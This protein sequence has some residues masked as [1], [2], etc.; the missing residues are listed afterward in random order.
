MKYD[1]TEVGFMWKHILYIFY[2]LGNESKIIVKLLYVLFACSNITINYFQL[3]IKSFTN[4]FDH[5][6]WNADGKRS[7]ICLKLLYSFLAL[8]TYLRNGFFELNRKDFNIFVKF[9]EL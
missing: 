5:C 9:T 4:V 3:V 6:L 2:F 1:I 7:Q 8:F